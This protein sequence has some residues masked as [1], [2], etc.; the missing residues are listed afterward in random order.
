MH[1]VEMQQRKREQRCDDTRNAKRSPEEATPS[2]KKGTRYHL[3]QRE[4]FGEKSS[5]E[6]DR[7]FLA[8]V[9]IR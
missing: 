4:G 9:E 7:K 5:P 6:T 8:R 3:L 2:C 1:A